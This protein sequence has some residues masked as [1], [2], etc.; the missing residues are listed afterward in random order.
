M[1]SNKPL[2]APQ[3]STAFKTQLRKLTRKQRESIDKLLLEHAEVGASLALGAQLVKEP[4]AKCPVI[5]RW[6][7]GVYLREI[8]MPFGT[9]ILGKRHKTEHFNIMLTGSIRYIDENGKPATLHAPQVFVS[10]AGVLKMFVV[11]QTCR[12]QTIHANPDDCRDTATLED[13]LIDR[14]TTEAVLLASKT[15]LKPALA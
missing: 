12:W 13:R 14:N 7:P 2:T 9:F 4:Q 8:E 15:Q 6:A 1:S 10:G 3:K 5:E 11:L